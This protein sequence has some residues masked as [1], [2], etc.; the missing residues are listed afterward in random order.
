M[1]RALSLRAAGAR[2][3][4]R[5]RCEA[6]AASATSRETRRF[7]A[8]IWAA[9][10]DSDDPGGAALT[11]GDP[12]R[13][14]TAVAAKA[15]A[16]GAAETKRLL[17]ATSAATARRVTDRH[18]AAAEAPRAAGCCRAGT[19]SQRPARRCASA[20]TAEPALE[21]AA[22]VA[23]AA[24]AA[25]DPGA[26]DGVR[27]RRGEGR[28]RTPTATRHRAPPLCTTSQTRHPNAR[29]TVSSS[30]FVSHSG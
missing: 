15:A 18:C 2:E 3:H 28:R 16:D 20:A 26:R 25:Y 17:A 5:P 8:A 7:P 19:A 12:G 9:R 10:G 30:F 23:N 29:A 4:A 1:S 24:A 21:V 14:R 22:G 27:A 13:A 6:M 11:G